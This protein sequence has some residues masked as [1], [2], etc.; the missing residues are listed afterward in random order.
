MLF[1]GLILVYYVI[2]VLYFLIPIIYNKIFDYLKEQ[3]YIIHLYDID[4]KA[5]DSLLNI[6]ILMSLS[7]ASG[8][9]VAKKIPLHK[10]TR[11]FKEINLNKYFFQFFLIILI[12]CIF[13]VI[14]I[15]KDLLVD[16]YI[17]SLVLNNQGRYL[18]SL[19]LFNFLFYFIFILRFSFVSQKN[20]NIDILDVLIASLFIIESIYIEQ[21][22]Q[23]VTIILI[24]LL[25]YSSY[26]KLS[27]LKIIYSSSLMITLF[28]FI[29]YLRESNYYDISITGSL[30][31]FGTEFYYA[32]M[33]LV[34]TLE[35]P[36]YHLHIFQ[37][38]FFYSIP[39]FIFSDRDSYLSFPLFLE[40]MGGREQFSPYGG[41]LTAAQLY[42]SS[43]YFGIIVFYFLFPI[44]LRKF[45]LLFYLNKN[46]LRALS[47]YM[48]SYVYISTIR[49]PLY[50]TISSIAKFLFLI[51]I[52]YTILFILKEVSAKNK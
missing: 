33:S 34:H 48:L 6:L 10:K 38:S 5:Y 36:L 21:R 13:L 22:F 19:N 26:N 32:S 35:T 14:Y 37:D 2:N 18:S 24:L 29:I 23:I 51:T 30:M 11:N 42:A 8:Y 17:R 16:H 43:S 44:I 40:K 52:V 49:T 7:Y 50:I 20:E 12:I 9:M 3:N 39:K 28:I 4:L 41:F 25:V 31:V 27:I 45:L 15:N 46:I 47:L 1:R